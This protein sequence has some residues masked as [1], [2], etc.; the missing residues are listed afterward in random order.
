MVV[1]VFF[2]GSFFYALIFKILSDQPE[3]PG[4]VAASMDPII[5][6][7]NTVI[8]LGVVPLLLLLL[9]W[10][11]IFSHRLVGPLKRLQ[12]N[13][14]EMASSGNFNKRLGVRKYDYIKP[15]VESI[16]RVLDKLAK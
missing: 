2:V 16:N 10:G 4:F 13:L 9:I 7:T 14:D 3:T 1:P 8:M 5:K 15:L 12:R 6:K 11:V